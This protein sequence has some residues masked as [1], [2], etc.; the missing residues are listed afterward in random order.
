MGAANKTGSEQKEV[1]KIIGYDGYWQLNFADGSLTHHPSLVS[2]LDNLIKKVM[3]DYIITHNDKDYHQ[4]HVAVAKSV[5][6]ANRSY[7]ASLLTFPSQDF[8]MPFDANLYIDIS[9]YFNK[10]LKILRKY[11]TQQFR[12][13][14]SEGLIRAKDNGL[15]VA[16]YME[17]FHIEFLKL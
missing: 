11:K 7:S 13:W 12:P 14:F 9:R 15:E 2:N 1:N 4:D 16:K 10:K 8:K 5:K 17:K 6:S 3:P